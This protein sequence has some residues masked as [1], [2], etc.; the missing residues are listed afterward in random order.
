MLCPENN[1]YKTVLTTYVHYLNKM[2][3]EP[4]NTIKKTLKATSLDNIQFHNSGGSPL[5]KKTADH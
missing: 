3:K 5:K 4:S 2:F 1:L